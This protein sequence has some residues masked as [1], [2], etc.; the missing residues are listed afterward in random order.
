MKGF[1]RYFR[2][3]SIL[4]AQYLAL[5]LLLTVL[6]FVLYV[7]RR[8]GGSDG[9]FLFIVSLILCAF[10]TVFRIGNDLIIPSLV[11]SFSGTRRQVFW[12]TQWMLLMMI[13]GILTLIGI[14]SAFFTIRGVA[15]FLKLL[16][17][18]IG[19]FTAATGL[20]AL[21]SGI[22]LKFGKA[23]AVV[24]S[25]CSGIF[26]GIVGFCSVSIFSGSVFRQFGEEAAPYLFFGGLIIL[27]LGNVINYAVF[28]KIAVDRR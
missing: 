14:Y 8:Q 11:L 1:S 16:P 27:I 6:C 10:I 18:L 26:G 22:V 23:A 5:S 24:M 9:S 15:G 20:G 28:R 25:V 2:Y 17:S 4:A 7:L 3:Y 19:F 12:G 13:S 21:L